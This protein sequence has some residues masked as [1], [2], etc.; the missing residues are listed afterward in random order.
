MKEI[1]WRASERRSLSAL[2]GGIAANKF[3][4]HPNQSFS[5]SRG[6]PPHNRI[7]PQEV[8]FNPG[9]GEHPIAECTHLTHCWIK[10]VV[11]VCGPGVARFARR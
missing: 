9:A 6:L 7:T 8:L 4:L 11:L 10:I 3:A 1:R 5:T 2:Y